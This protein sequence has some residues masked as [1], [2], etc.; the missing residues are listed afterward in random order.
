MNGFAPLNRRASRAPDKKSLK[1][2]LLNHWSKF[3]I[4]SQNCSSGYPLPKLHK[5]FCSAERN[6]RLSFRKEI[7]LNNISFLTTSIPGRVA[8]SVTCLATDANLTADPG[9]ARL[10]PTQSYTFLEIDHELIFTVILFSFAESF[11]KGCCQLP[12]KVSAGI[13]G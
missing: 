3:K 10:I 9:V 12:A 8:Q 11:M 13:T 2:H 1:R 4:N 7:S 5:I 6:G